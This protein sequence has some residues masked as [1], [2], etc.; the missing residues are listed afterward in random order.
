MRYQIKTGTLKPRTVTDIFPFA[1]KIKVN[2]RFSESP[3]NPSLLT[4]AVNMMHQTILTPRCPTQSIHLHLGLSRNL[5][6]GNLFLPY[7]LH[8]IHLIP[9]YNMT[10]PSTYSLLYSPL[11]AIFN[12]TQFLH[13]LIPYPINHSYTNK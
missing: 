5:S 10:V 1:I 12:T 4:N 6:P 8:Y 7:S 9:S 3:P 11:E 2:V 13:D